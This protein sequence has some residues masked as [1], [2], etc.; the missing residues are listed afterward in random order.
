[1]A[2]YGRALELMGIGGLQKTTAMLIDG[3]ETHHTEAIFEVFYLTIVPYFKVR[4]SYKFDVEVKQG[5]RD[6]RKGEQTAIARQRGPVVEVDVTWGPSNPGAAH[7]KYWLDTEGLLHVES[8]VTVG[9]KHEMT[10][11]VSCVWQS[12][13][14][15]CAHAIERSLFISRFSFR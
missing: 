13:A 12:C 11:Q 10:L 14:S 1:V 5:R 6:L 15:C 3:M 7:E 2:A 9:S 8:T 4:E